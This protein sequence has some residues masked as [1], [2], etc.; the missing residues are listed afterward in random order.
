MRI[1]NLHITFS[2]N[3]IF[4]TILKKTNTKIVWT[5]SLGALGFKHKS[6]K[7]TEAFN[8]LLIKTTEYLLLNNLKI[9]KVCL[10]YLL[11]KR[12]K[13]IKKQLANWQLN[14]IIIN[15]STSHN[16]CR[17]KKMPEKSMAI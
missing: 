10:N 14:T 13:I 11:K 17:I 16:G 4:I 12:I 6:K 15:H 7:I 9:Y 8:L 2:Q 5:Q 3:N 1:I